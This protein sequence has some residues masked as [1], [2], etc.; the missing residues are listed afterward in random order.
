MDAYVYTKETV[1]QPVNSV[2]Q[3]VDG[4]FDFHL[5]TDSSD[6]NIITGFETVEGTEEL[7]QQ[8]TFAALKQRGSDPLDLTSGVQWAEAVLGE[9]ATTVTMTQ[10]Q[11]EVSDVST[12]ISVLFTATETDT[13]GFYIEVTA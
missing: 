4:V 6:D 13:L 9:V 7:K 8:G 1:L 2:E 10:V 3:Y 12:S 5:T 11:K